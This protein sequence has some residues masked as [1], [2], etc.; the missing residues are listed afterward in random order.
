MLSSQFTVE[1]TEAQR[2]R[3][4]VTC[5]RSRWLAAEPGFEIRQLAS[6]ASALSCC[7]EQPPGSRESDVKPVYPVL[8]I[9]L[10]I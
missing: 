7:T 5:S 2:E 6:G 9:P 10:K 8:A 3:E 1:E 4:E